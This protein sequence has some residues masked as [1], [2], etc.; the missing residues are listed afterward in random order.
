MFIEKDK[1]YYRVGTG[2]AVG[3]CSVYGKKG[4]RIVVGY[5]LESPGGKVEIPYDE[6]QASYSLTKCVEQP[7]PQAPKTDP[8]YKAQKLNSYI[9]Q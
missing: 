6:F 2:A 7:K 4:N 9:P 3:R 8:K 5:R 1:T